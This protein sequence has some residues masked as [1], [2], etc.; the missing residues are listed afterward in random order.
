MC[1]EMCPEIS[2]KINV[3][4]SSN[5]TKEQHVCVLKRHKRSMCMSP[6]TSQKVNVDVS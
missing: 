5:V 6:E 4:V 1:P 2:Q 3:Y